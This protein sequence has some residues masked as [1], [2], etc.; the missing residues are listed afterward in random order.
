MRLLRH[1]ID[2]QSSTTVP[3]SRS[4]RDVLCRLA[5]KFILGG[6]LLVRFFPTNVERMTKPIE[7]VTLDC[8]G[9]GEEVSFG[10]SRL[11]TANDRR[12]LLARLRNCQDRHNATR[13]G[14]NPEVHRGHTK[15]TSARASMAVYPKLSAES[16]SPKQTAT[17]SNRI[18]SLEDGE[19]THQ[20]T[21]SIMSP[22]QQ[23]HKE[24]DNGRSG[25]RCRS[26][27]AA[28][29]RALLWSVIIFA[30]RKRANDH[31]NDSNHPCPLTKCWSCTNG[32]KALS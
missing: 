9:L 11:V 30:L 26:S 13:L 5:S 12:D 25:R 7:S 28:Q 18:S 17:V 10:N 4:H 1:P 27:G 29:H 2:L 24:H 21:T 22:S 15:R 14:S 16:K 31:D 19:Q 8:R 20:C 3:P 6:R 23:L 32:P